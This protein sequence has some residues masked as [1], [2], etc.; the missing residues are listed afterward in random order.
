MSAMI[1]RVGGSRVLE[2]QRPFDGRKIAV[3][4]ADAPH[5]QPRL[6]ICE[7]ERA[8]GPLVVEP[9]SRPLQLPRFQQL[10][11]R[12]AA[13]GEGEKRPNVLRPMPRFKSCR[14][15]VPCLLDFGS[16]RRNRL[17]TLG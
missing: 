16:G 6:R 4:D 3:L 5:D 12:L 2:V 17:H 13:V 8:L 11:R 9:A 14:H 7:G 15:P 10:R 1:G